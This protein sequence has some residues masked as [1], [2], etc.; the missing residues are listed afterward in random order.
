MNE[1]EQA[2]LFAALLGVLKKENSKTKKVLTK[3]LKEFL[4]SEIKEKE[5]IGS[6]GKAGEPGPRGERGPEGPMGLQ[7]LQG[8]T[9][10]RGPQGIKGDT[11]EQGPRGEIGEK[12][13]TGDRGPQGIRGEAG[14]RGPQGI[15][16]PKGDKGDKGE[17]G[18]TGDR[19][20]RGEIGDTGAQGPKGERGE[21]GEKGETGAQGSK[22]ENG[23][24]GE[25]GPKGERG[26]RGPQGIQ[27]PKGDKGER[28]DDGI[29]PD[30]TPIKKQLETQFEKLRGN[31]DAKMTQI[32][33]SSS[34]GGGV[35]RLTEL[36]DVDIS[37]IANGS[38]MVYN[39]E[40]GKFEFSTEVSLGGGG[41]GGGLTEEQVLELLNPP[42][43]SSFSISPSTAEIGSTVTSMK[44][45]YSFN[46]EGETAQINNSIGEIENGE[47]IQGLSFRSNKT[48][49]LTV[50][51]QEETFTR[52]ASLSFLNR[53]YVFVS[54]VATLTGSELTAITA[55]ELRTNKNVSAVYD[56]TGGNY[57]YIAYPSRFGQYSDVRVG[58]F[59]FTDLTSY[60]IQVTNSSGYS[61]T[62]NVYR[63]NN[64]LNGDNIEVVW[65]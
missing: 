2:K 26:E 33:Y 52:N 53:V 49:T 9:G 42:S 29:T 19:G 45:N 13:D 16:G 24:A 8:K 23:D 14:E 27:G 47:T 39:Q 20:P 4:D 30:I 57:F 48:F 32:S 62:Y 50:N 12:G 60:V 22:G 34:S 7:G 61:E 17:K 36:D 38:V 35:V 11:G 5:T 28:G 21:R 55:G 1:V 64:L 44:F 25:R 51:Y 3:E 31:I 46:K 58:G 18:D 40:S 54:D 59:A 10:E 15:Q 37:S 41:T 65:R 56:C 43:L 63:S 6:S